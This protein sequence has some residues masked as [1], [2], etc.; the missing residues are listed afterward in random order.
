MARTTT[1]LP[2]DL[3]PDELDAMIR[4]L[5]RE[6]GAPTGIHP[7][8]IGPDPEYHNY[9]G[10]GNEERHKES[11]Q[12]RSRLIQE[13]KRRPEWIAQWRAERDLDDRIR[14][15]CEAQGLTFAPWEMPPWSAPD[16]VP[17]RR[18]T[19]FSDI[20]RASLPQAVK[21]RRRLIAELEAD[22]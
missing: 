6:M 7:D 18:D 4:D 20:Y 15:L 13:L 19:E 12:W 21:L 16:E 2:G 11:V 14:C 5:A 17:E 9:W 10:N 8:L 22:G 1:E 3:D